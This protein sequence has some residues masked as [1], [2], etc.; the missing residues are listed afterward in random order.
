MVTDKQ[1]NKPPK[2]VPTEYRFLTEKEYP[3]YIRYEAALHLA[4]TL[5]EENQQAIADKQAK[6]K[7]IR[8]QKNGRQ[9][10]AVKLYRRKV[11]KV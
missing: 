9:S 2:V 8:R 4:T 6:V 7:I 5:R 11:V 10:F 3:S 1:T